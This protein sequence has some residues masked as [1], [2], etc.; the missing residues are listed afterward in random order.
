[1]M[2]TPVITTIIP[3]YRRPKLLRRAL[4]SALN[5]TYASIE[6]HVYDNASGD[7]TEHVVKEFAEKDGRVKY[8]RH[9]QNIGMLANYQYALNEVQTPYFSFL[10]DD[11]VIFPW[12]YEEALE[13]LKEFPQSAFFAGTTIVMTEKGK[14]FHSSL[15]Y[16]N[17]QGY[18]VSPEGFLEMIPNYPVPTCIV[19]NRK[20][21]EGVT[22]DMQNALTWDCDFLLQIASRS[23]I[24]ISKR[25]CGIFLSH[26]ASFSTTQ[27]F[28]NWEASLKKLILRVNQNAFLSLEVKEKAVEQ[29]LLH[30]KL[31][32]RSFILRSLYRKKFTEATKYAQ[33]FKTNYGRTQ[34]S[35]IFVILTLLCRWIRPAFY[36]LLLLRKFKKMLNARSK[37]GYEE[38]AKWLQI[39]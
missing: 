27:E 34:E 31:I 32:T 21:I 1:M 23:S 6:V 8:H 7:E 38:Y 39:S 12:F 30:L 35:V 26:D 10:S 28:E 13:R 37:S 4:S 19:F 15:D 25:P 20:L 11:D 33:M 29:I 14:A 2:S 9:P 36:G 18:V 5:Q 24:F 17:K 16:W 22:I 3:T